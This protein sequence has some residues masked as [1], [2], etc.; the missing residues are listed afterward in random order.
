MV[1][2]SVAHKKHR[3]QLLLLLYLFI[4]WTFILDTF[5]VK[6][7]PNEVIK[8]GLHKVVRNFMSYFTIEASCLVSIEVVTNNPFWLYAKK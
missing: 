4:E 7:I 2:V 1:I 8:V 5:Y 3:K 6:S